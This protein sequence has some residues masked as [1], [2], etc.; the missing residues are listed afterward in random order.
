MA[1]LGRGATALS[2]L[3][4]DQRQWLT[5]LYLANFPR[6]LRLCRRMLRNPDDAEDAAHEVFL[7]AIGPSQ[8]RSA[9]EEITPW[10]LTVARNHCLDVLRRRQRLGRVLVTLSAEGDATPDPEAQVAD[11]EV[12]AAIFEQLRRRERQ[13]LWQSAVERRPLAAIAHDLRLSYMATAQLLH[14]ARKHA[15]AV[16]ARLAAIFGLW[17]LGRALRR[18]SLAGSR[19]L[20]SLR[21]R[22]LGAFSLSAHHVLAIA[23]FAAVPVVLA[24]VPSSSSSPQAPVVPPS[25]SSMPG[26]TTLAPGTGLPVPPDLPGASGVL[27]RVTPLVSPV[28]VP[29]LPPLS[30][31]QASPVASAANTLQQ[32]VGPLPV[33]TAAATDLVGAL[34]PPRH[35]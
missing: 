23:A 7:R 20:T 4:G 11:R 22:S 29:S 5:D 19:L 10:L 26:G 33:P 9:G 15:A 14:R 21:P 6:V 25:L 18:A 16:A 8:L 24:S 30:L 13:A 2:P 32:S 27:K 34:L 35:L 3:S 12:V 1:E 31:P 28:A 17:Q